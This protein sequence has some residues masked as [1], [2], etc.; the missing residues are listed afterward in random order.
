MR[1]QQTEFESCSAQFKTQ[2]FCLFVFFLSWSKRIPPSF[3]LPPGDH[4]NVQLPP[5]GHVN[6]G[7][8]TPVQRRQP[9]ET[10][11]LWISNFLQARMWPPILP[12]LPRSPD[13][14]TVCTLYQLTRT[15][16]VLPP[17]SLNYDI[18]SDL[19][20]NEWASSLVSYSHALTWFPERIWRWWVCS[21]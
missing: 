13:D 16:S 11:D 2:V 10:W 4:R 17:N 18:N 14:P 12:T 20:L 9:V 3:V 6:I 15:D 21:Y 19:L 8:P 1:K 5:R 7:V